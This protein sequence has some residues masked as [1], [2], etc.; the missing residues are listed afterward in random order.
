MK[1]KIQIKTALPWEK[2]EAVEHTFKTWKE[3][4]NF[5]YRLAIQTDREIRVEDE[6]GKGNYFN[7]INALDF[8]N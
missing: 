6:G 8:L 1:V 4:C 3:V 5:A 2:I 7:P